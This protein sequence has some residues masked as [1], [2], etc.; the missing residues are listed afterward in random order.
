M[1]VLV[2]AGIPELQV[3]KICTYNSAKVLRR[4]EEFGSI[5][6]GKVADFLIVEGNPANDI[7]D[8]RK[9]EHVFLRGNQIDRE[10]L[11]LAQ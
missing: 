3:I 6:V 9:I 2:M 7:S 8:S 4:E 10:S 1:E 5:Q 11:K